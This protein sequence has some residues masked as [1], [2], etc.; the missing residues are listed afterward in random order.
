MCACNSWCGFGERLRVGP[1]SVGLWR[2]RQ[3]HAL[4]GSESLLPKFPRLIDA[5]PFE[6][7]R[8]LRGPWHG[9]SWFAFS[10]ALRSKWSSNLKHAPT[11]TTCLG[12]SSVAATQVSMLQCMS[13]YASIRS[14]CAI[15]FS[16]GTCERNPAA[17]TL[18]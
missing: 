12:L 18:R 7:Y 14:V 4:S 15:A 11:A 6:G 1:C 3:T 10:S 5:A 13:Y 8:L 16:R 2:G 17:E 9:A